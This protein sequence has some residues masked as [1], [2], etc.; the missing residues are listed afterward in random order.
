MKK[1]FMTIVI[2]IAMAVTAQGQTHEY[3][4]QSGG[5]YYTITDSVNQEVEVSPYPKSLPYPNCYMD[6][7]HMV[8]PATVTH[9]GITY[10]VTAIGAKAF[11]TG[12]AS[13]YTLPNTIRVIGDKS[14][15]GT[16]LTSLVVPASVERIGDYVFCNSDIE[17]ISLPASVRDIGT[18]ALV[19][20]TSLTTITVDDSN[21]RY[22]AVDNVLYNKMM[23]TL[24]V[25]PTGSTASSYTIPSG[26]VAIS[27]GA[28]AYAHLS[29]VQLPDGLQSIGDV[30]FKCNNSLNNIYIPATVTHIGG[31]AFARDNGLS[32]FTIDSNNT[33]YIYQSQKE[34]IFTR[35]MDTLVCCIRNTLNSYVIP[36]GIRVIMNEAC[37][38]NWMSSVT[39]PSTLRV[40]GDAA[41]TACR[42]INTVTLNKGLQYI[43]DEAFSLCLGLRRFDMPNTVT[44][45]GSEAVS[46]CLQLRAV[47]LSDSLLTISE[48]AFL[49]CDRLE[50]LTWGSNIQRVGK[51]AF[52][53]CEKLE[54]TMILPATLHTVDDEAFYG[55]KISHI[56]FTGPLN[57][58]GS[59]AFYL[60]EMLKKVTLVDTMPPTIDT[61]AF[62]GCPIDTVFIPC[63][64]RSR[65]QSHPLWGTRYRYV[66]VCDTTGG[67]T[68]GGAQGIQHADNGE[69]MVY[70]NPAHD[71]LYITLPV[72]PSG[73][74]LFS[75]IDMRGKT[76]LRIPIDSQTT[77]HDLA[78][79]RL[80]PGLYFAVI[81]TPTHRWME[82]LVIY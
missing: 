42:Y 70:P 6:T 13:G 67:G 44:Y 48:K 35:G 46:N 40:I 11:Y 10:T 39:M 74:V 59:D 57:Y 1:T 20:C 19:I 17:S 2:V 77:T 36:E 7:A 73:E 64:T 60:W 16:P 31:G 4:F 52:Q 47:T 37:I 28:F 65:Y 27:R 29:S 54:G 45:L 12:R 26:V 14:F 24:I 38:E 22:T 76:W 8:I 69:L 51:Q 78:D 55:T 33:H 41:F 34:S 23:D 72:M 61:N 79:L 49:G 58:L 15:Y 30:A 3:D 5:V 53:S 9:N 81:T 32:N 68:G 80:S 75:L 56:I 18:G 66:E 62:E 43:G 21:T 25:Y 50:S 63:G 71:R 82:K